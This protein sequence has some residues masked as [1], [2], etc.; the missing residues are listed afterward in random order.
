M[1]EGSRY[2]RAQDGRSRQ[3]EGPRRGCRLARAE[4][5]SPSDLGGRGRR[6]G[7][8]ERRMIRELVDE[9][10]AAGARRWRA[11]E[12]LGLTARTLERWGVDED[13]RRGPNTVPA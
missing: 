6:H 11:C 9:A 8:G 10:V 3:G 5:K 1:A 7:P 13:G 12:V 2:G 4:K